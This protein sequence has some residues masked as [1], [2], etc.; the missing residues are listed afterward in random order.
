VKIKNKP[1]EINES[2]VLIEKDFDQYGLNEIA[3]GV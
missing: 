2:D 1:F 3:K